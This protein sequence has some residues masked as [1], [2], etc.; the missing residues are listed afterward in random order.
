MSV[1]IDKLIRSRRKTVGLEVTPEAFLIIRAP[2]NLSRKEISEIVDKESP[3]ILKKQQF[4]RQNHSKIREKDFIEGEEFL[5]LGKSYKL[6]LVHNPVDALIVSN[7]LFYLSDECIDNARDIIESWYRKRAD[8]VVSERAAYYSCVSGIKFKKINISNA[9]KR[10]G[11]CSPNGNLNIAWRLVMAPLRVIDYV[12]VHELSHIEMRNHS[13][14]FWRRV[15]SV[16]PD[17][18]TD[19]K[20]LRDNGHFLVL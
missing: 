13:K 6:R 14:R 17:Y 4:F 15:G 12:I 16:I 10:W 8:E 9:K 1:K 20:W 11:S 7:N 18:K 2:R 3:W 5:Y 19:E